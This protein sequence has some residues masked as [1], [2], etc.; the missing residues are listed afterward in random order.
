MK[1]QWE[2]FIDYMAREN[3]EVKAYRQAYPKTT[4]DEAARVSAA[5]LLKN[6]TIK[7]EIATR[8]SGIVAIADHAAAEEIK[9][10]RKRAALSLADK[11]EILFHIA[12]G[13]KMK[14]TEKDGTTS[15]RYPEDRDR[16]RAIELDNEITGE[17]YR[18][19]EPGSTT[20]NGPVYNTVVRKTVFKT[21]V[22]SAAAQTFQNPSNE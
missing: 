19:P 4:S 9:T 10:E 1:R 2:V 22:T 15:W 7:N 3:D 13:K 8:R 12:K 6:A 11:R 18:P 5:R 21:R 14:F 16:I 20:I 17:G